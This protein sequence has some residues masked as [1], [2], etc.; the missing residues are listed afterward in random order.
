VDTDTR[1]VAGHEQLVQFDTTSN[2]LDEDD[3]LQ[4]YQPRESEASLNEAYLVELQSVKELVQ[5]PVL[6]DLFELNVVLLKAVEGQ[7]RL[8]VDKDF[9]RLN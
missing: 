4:R 9:E 5:L 3:D 2:R 7:L 8:V 6:L 1:E